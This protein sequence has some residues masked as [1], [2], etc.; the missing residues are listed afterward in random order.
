VDEG[1]NR[2]ISTVLLEVYLLCFSDLAEA[3]AEN[4][5]T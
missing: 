1:G 4:K 3:T 2:K 5:A